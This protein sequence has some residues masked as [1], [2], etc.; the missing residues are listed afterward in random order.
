MWEVD[1]GLEKDFSNFLALLKKDGV[2][3]VIYLPAF[4]PLRY[5]I[6]NGMDEKYAFKYRKHAFEEVEK[7]IRSVAKNRD[8]TV[9]GS[10]DPAQAHIGE[11]EFMD[12][13][14][15]RSEAGVRRLL[16]SIG[17]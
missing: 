14:H 9:V 13:V 5:Q 3:V 10:Y 16:G 7:A 12:G 15:Q 1:R 4:H 8:V 2:E 17:S 6:M 11:T